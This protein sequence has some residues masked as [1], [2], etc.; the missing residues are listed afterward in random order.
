MHLIY[1]VIKLINIFG[2][3][4][5]FLNASHKQWIQEKLQIN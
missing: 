1:D 2:S 5:L 4:R 3:I